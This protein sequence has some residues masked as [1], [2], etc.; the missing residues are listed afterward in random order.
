MLHPTTE[1]PSQPCSLLLYVAV[2]GYLVGSF[3]FH[4]FNL[5]TLDMREKKDRKGKRTLNKVRG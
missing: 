2:F 1:I 5:L 4:P 3:F